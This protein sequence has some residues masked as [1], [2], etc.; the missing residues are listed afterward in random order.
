MRSAAPHTTAP[1]ASTQRLAPYAWLIILQSFVTNGVLFGIWFSFAVF[2]VAM[3]EEFHWSRGGAAAAFSV[4]SIMQAVSAPVA[5]L[6]LDRWG[7]R[8]IVASGLGIMALG[9]AACSLVQALWHLTLLFGVVV[10]IG[11]G[12]AGQVSQSAL[13]SVWFVKRRGTIIGFAFAGMGLGVQLIGPLAQR[14]ILSLGWRQTFVVLASGVAVYALAV[15]LTLRNTPRQV[16]LL[17]YGAAEQAPAGSGAVATASRPAAHPWTVAQALR[18]RE[19]W[20]LSLAQVLIPTGIFPISVHQVAYLTDL[21]FAKLVAA[22]ILGHMGLMSALGRLLFGAMSDRL[23][24]FGGVTLS[25]LCS[26]IGILVLLWVSNDA[27]LWPLYVY[28]VFFG[29]GYGARGPII[30]AIA[31]DLF[32][33][34]SFGTIFG[35]MSIGHGLGGAFGPWYGGYVYDLLGSYRPAFIMAFCALFGVI[36][37]FWVATRRLV[38]PR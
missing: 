26:Q 30:S 8:R 35:L 6:L 5:G 16:G 25:V 10:G 7:P 36:A 24:R 20:A 17:P 32:P 15:A 23:G 14:L 38:I 9:L 28:A 18:T 21:G 19:F 27:V 37:C 33:G 31:A 13:L 12:L 22:A 29:L 11:I 4:G 34:R 2:F 1:S 3:L